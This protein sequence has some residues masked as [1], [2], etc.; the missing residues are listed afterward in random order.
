MCN[1]YFIHI[2]ESSHA[3]PAEKTGKVMIWRN[4]FHCCASYGSLSVPSSPGE[5]IT[6]C[7]C[8]PTPI[9]KQYY[10]PQ[11]HIH[12]E[13]RAERGSVQYKNLTSYF[14]SYGSARAAYTVAGWATTIKM[15][16]FV[17]KVMYVSNRAVVQHKTVQSFS[18]LHN[19]N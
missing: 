2:H 6:V 8:F 9:Q 17:H 16:V 4:I 18:T 11:P 7:V 13:H 12:T 3:F 10:Q 5:S 14:S 1:I 19:C 15:S